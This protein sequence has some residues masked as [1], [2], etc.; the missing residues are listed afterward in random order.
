MKNT[1]QKYF[2]PH[3]SN[4]YKPHIL[5]EVSI[6]VLLVATVALFLFSGSISLFISKTDQ[7]A[8]IYSSLLVDLTNQSRVGQRL[9]ALNKNDTLTRAAQLKADDMAAKSY[10]SH[11]SPEGY[12]PW[13][14]F[15]E[16]GYKFNHAGENLAVDFKETK[17]VE[18]A[19]MNSPT[20]RENILNEK[21]TEIGIATAKGTYKDHPTTYVVQ[22]FGHPTGENTANVTKAQSPYG[23]FS[24]ALISYPYVLQFMYILCAILIVTSLVMMIFTESKTKRSRHVLYGILIV[25]ILIALLIMNKEFILPLH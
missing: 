15:N 14:W 18:K 21:F 23:A 13:H 17:N 12:T 1:V 10:F 7:G 5:S 25:V 24:Y 4:D 20:H 8:A 3:E 9:S 16:A 2:V 6:G 11:T 22:M 19:W